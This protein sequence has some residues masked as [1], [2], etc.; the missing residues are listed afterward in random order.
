MALNLLGKDK[1]KGSL[2]K[3]LCRAALHDA[4]LAKLLVASV[5]ELLV[6]F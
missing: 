5:N 4:F 2:P 1:S 6:V 3:K